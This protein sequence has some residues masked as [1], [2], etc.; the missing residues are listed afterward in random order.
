MGDG[1][2]KERLGF[3]AGSYDDVVGFDDV[4]FVGHQFAAAGGGLPAFDVGMGVDGGMVFAQ[5]VFE[6]AGGGFIGVDLGSFLVDEGAGGFETAG[7]EEFAGGEELGRKVVFLAGLVLGFKQGEA[8]GVGGV[9]D[10]GMALEFGVDV[11]VAED[12]FEVGDG[13]QGSLVGGDGGFFAYVVDEMAEGEVGFVLEQGG[14]G[15]G[16]AR[17]DAAFVDEDARDAQATEFVSNEDA[18]ETGADDGDG[19]GGVFFEG[20]GVVVEGVF[21]YPVGSSC[22]LFHI[23]FFWVFLGL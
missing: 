5:E 9:A 15:G 21:D 1:T 2:R 18:G 8:G 23:F 13:A 6:E 16:A 10:A 7:V 12:C 20:V 17:A 14:A 22:M 19:S 3:G 4:A 11:G